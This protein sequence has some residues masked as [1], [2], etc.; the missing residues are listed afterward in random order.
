VRL[1]FSK[2]N[3]RLAS[4]P[5]D[6]ETVVIGSF[7]EL[8][9][10]YSIEGSSKAYWRADNAQIARNRWAY[11]GY[12]IQRTG[13]G[14]VAGIPCQSIRVSWSS[15]DSVEACLAPGV[16]ASN[17]W[18]LAYTL[19]DYPVLQALRADGLGGLVVKWVAREASG[20]RTIELTRFEHTSDS[21]RLFA[22]PPEYSD[23]GRITG[24]VAG[25][26]R[27]GEV[28]APVP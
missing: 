24:R 23:V 15:G 12:G 3:F 2:T 18:L 7:T 17:E 1:Y 26:E 4:G 16:A 14:E 9:K 25:R 20:T 21:T 6:R 5:P 13:A 22:L 19:L 28:K 11:Q 8:D 27:C 10:M